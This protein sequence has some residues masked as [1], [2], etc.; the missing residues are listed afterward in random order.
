MTANDP[1]DF[2]N[3]AEDVVAKWGHERPDN[4]ALLSVDEAGNETAWSFRAI[5][6]RSSRL[7]HV[8]RANGLVRGAAVLVMVSS[9]SQRIFAQLA[10]MKAGG[11]ILLVRPGSSA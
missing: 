3:F 5:D 1:P 10:V 9:V 11:V 4:V 7:A 8:L 6:E 2:F